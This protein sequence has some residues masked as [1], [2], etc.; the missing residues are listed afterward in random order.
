VS[1]KVL[2]IDPGTAAT[3]YAV[4][5]PK[6]GT[7]GHLIECGVIRTRSNHAMS[8]RLE[9]IFDGVTELIARHSPATVAV[10]TAFLKTNVQTTVTLG[11]AR[12][13]V[14]LAAAKAGAKIAEF[15][16]A[17]VKKSVSG[18]GGADKKQVAYMVQRLLRLKEPPKPDDAADACAI[19]LTYL[20][21]SG[22]KR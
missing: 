13:M 12:G 22:S 7:P 6:I 10:E 8:N 5:E 4:V 2:G 21:K 11:Q 19:A 9:T 1:D 17:T 18:T 20:I 3:G 15:T 16:P 14:L